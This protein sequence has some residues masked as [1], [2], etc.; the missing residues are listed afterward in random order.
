MRLFLSEDCPS[1]VGGQVRDLLQKNASRLLPISSSKDSNDLPPGFEGTHFLNPC[2]KELSCIPRVQ[3]KCPPNV[4]RF[5][6]LFSL[7]LA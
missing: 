7:L 3:W 5:S 2:I 1:E 4:S 6:Q